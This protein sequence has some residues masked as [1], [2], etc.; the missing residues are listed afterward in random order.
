MLSLS[1]VCCGVIKFHLSPTHTYTS[2]TFPIDHD[3]VMINQC[4]NKNHRRALTR[5]LPLG[6]LPG[7]EPV[8]YIPCWMIQALLWEPTFSVLFFSWYIRLSEA[9]LAQ[10]ERWGAEMSWH[11]TTIKTADQNHNSPPR[12][13]TT[14][15]LIAINGCQTQRFIITAAAGKAMA[16]VF[17]KWV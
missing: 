17:L 13:P 12:T 10:A 3:S 14:N 16:F 8:V 4:T 1:F 5:A 11:G 9:N 15:V 7:D 6:Y 2:S